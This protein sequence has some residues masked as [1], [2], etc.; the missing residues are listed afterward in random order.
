MNKELTSLAL[1]HRGNPASPHDARLTGV[2]AVVAVV[3][4]SQ[5][6][7][8]LLSKVNMTGAG[9]DGSLM[10]RLG[11]IAD[12]IEM[13]KLCARGLLAWWLHAELII[14]GQP[15]QGFESKR[16]FSSHPSRAPSGLDLTF[17]LSLGIS[18]HSLWQ[19]AISL[20]GGGLSL[21]AHFLVYW[22]VVVCD[23][24]EF[25]YSLFLKYSNAPGP[26]ADRGGM[27]RM[28]TGG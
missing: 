17:T 13:A 20:G 24:F 10:F 25:A 6:A 1:S 15:R 7:D 16:V 5:P 22:Y 11:R 28:A 9:G 12:G 2:V 19:E 18:L 4:I 26:S 14:A 3:I 8:G 21:M 27:P 23:L